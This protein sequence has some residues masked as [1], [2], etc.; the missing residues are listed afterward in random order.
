MHTGRTDATL[1]G[2]RA[3]A[4][5][6]P[7]TAALDRL[8]C[9]FRCA[10]AEFGIRPNIPGSHRQVE[11]HRTRDDRY[12]PRRVCRIHRDALAVLLQ[13]AH[14]PVGGGQTVGAAPG[15]QYRVHL[16]DGMAGI[17]QIGLPGARSP[18]TYIDRRRRAAGYPDHGA[19]G[20]GAGTEGRA[21]VEPMVVTDQ[22]TRHIGNRI[23]E[24]HCSASA[25]SSASAPPP[26]VFG[27][28]VLDFPSSGQ[29]EIEAGRKPPWFT[30]S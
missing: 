15:E 17:E 25:V 2:T 5:S 27:P 23:T 24:L 22:H 30:I 1:D 18:T 26:R 6:S 4:G 16:P 12:H 19:P 3:G 10:I 13:P 7:H 29:S 14:H 8:T 21:R 9:R 11:D 20:R 28:L